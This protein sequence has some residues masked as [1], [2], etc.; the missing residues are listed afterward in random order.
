MDEQQA[1][2]IA[3]IFDD[4]PTVFADD[5]AGGFWGVQAQTDFLDGEGGIIH[6]SIGS[7]DDGNTLAQLTTFRSG[8]LTD[9]YIAI[10]V[11]DDQPEQ[12]AAW[13]REN[14]GKDIDT[15]LAMHEP[16]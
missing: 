14:R 2:A 5:W 10:G 13:I 7:D 16:Y 4:D 1:K 8:Q 12:V 3:G 11:R 6:L 9:D 15:L